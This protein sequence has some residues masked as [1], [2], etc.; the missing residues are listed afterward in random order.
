MTN[1][2]AGFVAFVTRNRGGT[3]PVAIA[4]GSQERRMTGL[5]EQTPGLGHNQPDEFAEEQKT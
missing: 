1:G 4:T 3:A 5:I 2:Y